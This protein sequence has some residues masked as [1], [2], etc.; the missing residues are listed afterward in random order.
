MTMIHAWFSAETAL[1]HGSSVYRKPSGATVNVT[2]MNADL[3]SKGS[4]WHDEKYLGEASPVKTSSPSQR[5]TKRTCGRDQPA[6]RRPMKLN[7][8]QRALASV[9]CPR[10][11]AAPGQRCIMPGLRVE[12]CSRLSHRSVRV[13]RGCDAALGGA[14]GVA[15]E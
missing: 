5:M 8:P 2:R 3:A 4:F 1:R 12:D 11:H 10:C 14:G 7:E 13:R 9:R 15:A 6:Q